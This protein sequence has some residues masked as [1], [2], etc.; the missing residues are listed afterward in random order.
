MSPLWLQFHLCHLNFTSTFY[1]LTYTPSQH[2]CQ[3]VTPIITCSFHE[4]I[5]KILKLQKLRRK[6]LQRTSNIY[7]Y[8]HVYIPSFTSQASAYYHL[9]LVWFRSS[10]TAVLWLVKVIV[11][12]SWQE[13][14]N[15][16]W[17]KPKL[18]NSMM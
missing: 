11:L 16:V 9:Y 4:N 1:F 2:V 3:F 18:L 13:N 14:N 10:I 17:K 15:V 6:S 7:I 8:I 5:S 12:F